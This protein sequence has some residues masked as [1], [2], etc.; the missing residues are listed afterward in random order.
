MP[1][2]NYVVDRRRFLLALIAAPVAAL[3]CPWPARLSDVV[4]DEGL[5]NIAMGYIGEAQLISHVVFPPIEIRSGDEITI[6]TEL[7]Y[8]EA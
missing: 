3:V 1:T 2:Y 5:S 6:S 8:G 7:F 4:F